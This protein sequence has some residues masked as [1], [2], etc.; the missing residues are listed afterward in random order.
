M[1][2]HCTIYIP[3][4]WLDYRPFSSPGPALVLSAVLPP[5]SWQGQGFFLFILTHYGWMILKLNIPFISIWWEWLWRAA[6]NEALFRFEK[7]LTSRSCNLKTE[8]LP[9]VQLMLFNSYFTV[10]SVGKTIW[11]LVMPNSD[12]EGQ[13]FLY[14][15]N[16][17]ERFFFLHNLP[18]FVAFDHW[19]KLSTYWYKNGYILQ[20]QLY[21]FP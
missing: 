4:H 21:K 15:P 3:Y 20:L 16:K 9:T 6:C 11:S 7:Q 12:P 18:V 17:H 2:T 19:G 14:T 5:L 8:E 13:I 1:R 10:S